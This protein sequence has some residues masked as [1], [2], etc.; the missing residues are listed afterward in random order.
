[1]KLEGHIKLLYNF[2]PVYE[3]DREIELKVLDNGEEMELKLSKELF[4]EK[5]NVNGFELYKDNNLLA[6]RNFL[7]AEISLC[8]ETSLKL[9]L[10]TTSNFWKIKEKF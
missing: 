2:K 5:I 1:M 10:R 4:K 7:A 3:V 6:S 9:T 8:D